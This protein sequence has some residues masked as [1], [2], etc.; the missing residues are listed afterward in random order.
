MSLIR[1]SIDTK[2][3]FF[4]IKKDNERG[5]TATVATPLKQ[6]SGERPELFAVKE[7]PEGINCFSK[8]DLVTQI[9]SKSRAL[10]KR[11]QKAFILTL[12]MKKIWQLF[13]NYMTQELNHKFRQ[14]LLKMNFLKANL[15]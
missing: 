15:L 2:S 12:K 4:N 6:G 1:L 5:H 13:K 11:L 9:L 7:I 8:E 3:L 10:A 14:K